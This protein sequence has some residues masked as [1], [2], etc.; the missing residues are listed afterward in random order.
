MISG[1]TPPLDAGAFARLMA[2][3]EPFEASPTLAV[4]VSGG[5]DSMALALLSHGWA[6]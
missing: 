1:Q 3:F 2:T 4:A 6:A 5:R